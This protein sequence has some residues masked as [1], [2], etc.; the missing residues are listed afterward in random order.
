MY[1][2]IRWIKLSV[3]WYKSD[4]IQLIRKLPD[5]DSIALMFVML[6]AMAGDR[7]QAGYIPYSEEDIAALLDMPLNTVRMAM[8]AMESRGM[9]DF[10]DGIFHVTNWDK[11]QNV[12]GMEKIKE[13]NRIRKQNQREREKQKA[14]AAAQQPAL[15]E[16]E[17]KEPVVATIQLI[18]RDGQYE[19]TESEYRK[20]CE[21]YPAIDVMQE[22]RKM[23]GW[24]D[25]NPSN[26]KTKKGIR[27]FINSWLSRAQDRAPRVEKRQEEYVP[28]VIRD[29]SIEDWN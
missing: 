22:I 28:P 17:V 11:Y 18:Q 8:K 6:L 27:R 12:D 1:V 10:D 2:D 25:T 13:Q 21:L 15:P 20:F 4:D 9:V 19:I 7:N 26:R 3:N 16:P 14:L 23:I 5:G 29:E 24:C